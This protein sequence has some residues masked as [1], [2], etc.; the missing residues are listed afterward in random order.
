MVFLAPGGGLLPLPGCAPASHCPV[1]AGPGKLIDD[2]LNVFH[3]MC[4]TIRISICA[5]GDC[6]HGAEG[7]AA[8]SIQ[9]EIADMRRP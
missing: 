2:I 6:M 4:V 5:A 8:P 3:R 1:M 9:L 7:P